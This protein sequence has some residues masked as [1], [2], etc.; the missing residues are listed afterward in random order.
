M[1]KP[2]LYMVEFDIPAHQYEEWYQLIPL[3][4]SKVSAM[5]TGGIILNYVLASDRTRLW[6]V[7]SAENESKLIDLVESLPL[8]NYFVYNYHELMMYDSVTTY[9]SFSV[10]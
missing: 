7:F 1:T 9:A 10:N 4:R 8:T 6:A 3:Q 2:K 5:L